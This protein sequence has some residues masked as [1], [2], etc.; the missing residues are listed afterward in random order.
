MTNQSK[1]I[2]LF[3]D[4]ENQKTLNSETVKTDI[5]AIFKAY[6]EASFKQSDFAS[7]LSK[8]TQHINQI[9]KSLLTEKL[10]LREGSKKQYYYRLNK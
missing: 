9:L 5:I 8:R 1:A 7:R 10:I 3:K 2:G 6:P 4:L